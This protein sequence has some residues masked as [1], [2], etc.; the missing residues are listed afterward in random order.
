MD[1]VDL[2]GLPNQDRTVINLIKAAI[3][4][5][6]KEELNVIHCRMPSWH[7]YATF[8][9]RLRF[10]RVG[11]ALELAKLYQPTLITYPSTEEEKIDVNK[12]FYTLADTDY[13]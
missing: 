2:Q 12:W 9:R 11:K 13:A 7:R 8:L 10:T 6:A 4:M 5:A 3:D 1:I